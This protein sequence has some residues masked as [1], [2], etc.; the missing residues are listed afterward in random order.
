MYVDTFIAIIIRLSEMK[1]VD[2]A[3][4]GSENLKRRWTRYY[5]IEEKQSRISISTKISVS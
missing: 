2:R 1:S 3:R 5:E 4:I